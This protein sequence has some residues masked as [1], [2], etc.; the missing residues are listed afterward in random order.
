M[1]MNSQDAQLSSYHTCIIHKL[2]RAFSSRIFVYALLYFD[3][4]VFDKV[5][6]FH[7]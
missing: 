3:V 2:K 4:Y 6:N 1:I 5:V 7:S